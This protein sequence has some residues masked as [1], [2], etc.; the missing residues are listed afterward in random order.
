MLIGQQTKGTALDERALYG[1]MI[2]YTAMMRDCYRGMAL[3]R[4]DERW[5]V[6]ARQMDAL[7]DATKRMM[8]SRQTPFLILP[9]R[10]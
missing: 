4:G 5:L 8:T 6:P 10:G 9:G 3:L 7:A 2:E 1:R